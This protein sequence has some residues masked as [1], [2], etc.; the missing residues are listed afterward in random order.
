MNTGELGKNTS[1]MT[2]GAAYPPDRRP[3]FTSWDDIA[4]LFTDHLEVQRFHQLPVHH[5]ATA[6][7]ERRKHA[8]WSEVVPPTWDLDALYLRHPEE[9][10]YCDLLRQ[11]RVDVSLTSVSTDLV[12]FP[13]PWVPHRWPPPQHRIEVNRNRYPGTG[14]LKDPRGSDICVD[15]A[16]QLRIASIEGGTGEPGRMLGEIRKEHRDARKH[17]FLIPYQQVEFYEQHPDGRHRYYVPCPEWWRTEAWTS[18]H[19][20]VPIPPCVTYRASRLLR[21]PLQHAETPFWWLVFESE[22]VTLLFGRWCTD[23][24]QRGIMW[25]LPLR[26]RVGVTTM[27]VAKLLYKSSLSPSEVEKWLSEHDTYDWGATLMPYQVRGPAQDNPAEIETIQSF[28]RIYPGS[29]MS[30]TDRDARGSL[31]PSTSAIDDDVEEEILASGGPAPQVRASASTPMRLISAREPASSDRPVHPAAVPTVAAAN[32]SEY[33][34]MERARRAATARYEAGPS[35]MLSDSLMR[36]LREAG[37]MPMMEYY[38]GY[39]HTPITEAV[40]VFALTR[41]SE[42]S[43][44]AAKAADAVRAKWKDSEAEVT[45]LRVRLQRSEITASAL[46]DSMQKVQSSLYE[47]TKR[48]REE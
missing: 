39:Y 18:Q 16:W 17:N 10:G 21:G 43:E 27:G 19:M 13:A 40:L 31:P 14:D 11:L 1:T 36:Q 47:G 25:R 41:L 38:A 32:P 8:P 46:L 23:I 6:W 45:D 33:D 2:S 35:P 44:R 29:S 7:N 24:Q 9:R 37:H 28:V 15:S 22:W 34:R 30:G 12:C 4:R 48:S 20:F 42:D 5:R 3:P 26:G